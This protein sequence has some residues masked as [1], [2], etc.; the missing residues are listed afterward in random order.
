MDNV[1]VYVV[2]QEN[3]DRSVEVAGV[4][5]SEKVAYEVK[6]TLNRTYTQFY[7][8]KDTLLDVDFQKE[9]KGD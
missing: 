3:A 1:R 9:L 6:D 7:Y 4:Y 5:T 2:L 8:V